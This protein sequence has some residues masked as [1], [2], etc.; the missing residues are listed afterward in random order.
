MHTRCR[1]VAAVAFLLACYQAA[2]ARAQVAGMARMGAFP[3]APNAA[4]NGQVSSLARSSIMVSPAVSED[5][6]GARSNVRP[7]VVAGA[8][9]GMA[10]GLA[11]AA[12]EY[13]HYADRSAQSD[14]QSCVIVVVAAVPVIGLASFIGGY[15]GWRSADHP[16]PTPQN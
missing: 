10:A 5:S 9:L 16:R 3:V 1:P 14:C 15:L 4:D 8:L 11:L 12:F 2:P 6:T 13:R 7:H